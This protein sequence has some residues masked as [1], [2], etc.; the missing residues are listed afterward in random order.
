MHQ[1][2]LAA[3]QVTHNAL[4]HRDGQ[5]LRSS[6]CTTLSA[7]C[8]HRG[9]GRTA[10]GNIISLNSSPGEKGIPAPS[11][12]ITHLYQSP[13]PKESTRFWTHV[14]CGIFLDPMSAGYTGNSLPMCIGDPQNS[15]QGTNEVKEDREAALGHKER[16]GH[17]DT[18]HHDLRAGSGVQE[19]LEGRKPH[20][21]RAEV[22]SWPGL[23]TRGPTLQG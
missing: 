23:W 10:I 2:R 1:G 17:P 16:R 5:S 7:A 9:L 21:G 19:G 18:L 11:V 8:K 6:Q 4:Q 20:Q 14:G 3:G 13:R 15:Q 12:N 22:E